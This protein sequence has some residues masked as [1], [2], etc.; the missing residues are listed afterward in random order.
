[1]ATWKKYF[2]EVP[3]SHKL[4]KWLEK[5]QGDSATYGA[6]A[7]FQTWL[8]EVYAGPPNRIE[9]YK[10]YEEMDN[11]SPEVSKSL[12]TIAEFCTQKEEKS[13]DY[14][15]FNYIDEAS[16]PEVQVL[17][18]K[19]REWTELNDFDKRLWRILRSVILY[20][21]MFF[22]RDPETYKWLWIDPYNVEKVIV[23]EADG[24]KPEE[25]WVA[26]PDLNLQTLN[27][28]P[29]TKPN[30][31]YGYPAGLP[32]I[33]QAAGPSPVNNPTLT[34]T[35]ASS[36]G[37]LAVDATHIIHL[38][39]NEGLDS[40]WPFG[41]SILESVYKTWKQVSLL[42]DSILIYRVHRAPERRVFYI[43]VGNMP[44]N[45]AMAHLDK[46]KNEI[47]QRRIPT[48]TGGGANILDATYNPM[49]MTEDYFFPQSAD[50]R[51]SR[52]DTLPGAGNLGEINDLNYFLTQLKRGLNVPSAYIASGSQ[53]ETGVYNDGRATTALIA[54]YRFSKYCERI[55]AL[56][57]DIFDREFK[58]YLKA[59]GVNID[60]KI[61]SL[62]LNTPQ[63]FAKYRQIE[64]DNAM[65][66]TWSQLADIPYI[67]KRFAMKRWL[68]MTE[69]EIVENEKMWK[70]ENPDKVK[71]GETGD[72]SA[73]GDLRTLGVRP[74]IE[75]PGAFGE[76]EDFET[77]DDIETDLEAESPISGAETAGE[78]PTPPAPPGA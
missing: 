61:F 76:E 1:M 67:S 19:L 4:E 49:S 28:S 75:D 6:K 50:G 45:R 65:I 57:N 5:R 52:V 34:Q 11:G 71:T 69:D 70:E 9:R 35:H 73:D 29:S 3:D 41:L 64:L 15:E 40:N 51:G 21:D 13:K 30:L 26:N 33:Q 18:E 60:S 53:E 37:S 62:T 24:K 10:Q 8:P 46:I 55:Q 59:D 72:L 42:E 20:G 47:N 77:P 58:L 22:V 54:E 2:V 39:L 43:D 74:D 63:N 48:R 68:G 38:S 66:S 17:N 31:N 56:V 78:I 32:H 16:E 12:D 44:A 36:T 25:Y 23:N 14:F 7:N 27:I